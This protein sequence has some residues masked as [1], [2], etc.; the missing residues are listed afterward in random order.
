MEILYHYIDTHCTWGWS[1]FTTI[2]AAALAIWFG[3]LIVDKIYKKSYDNNTR[4]FAACVFV[5]IVLSGIMSAAISK[6]VS[7]DVYKVII[8]ES[9]IDYVE[10]LDTYEILEQEGKIYTI[11][12][13]E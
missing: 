10:F 4:F 1:P 13:R 3:I 6:K 5:V 8:D 9:S 11:K 2:C 7:Y 12:Y